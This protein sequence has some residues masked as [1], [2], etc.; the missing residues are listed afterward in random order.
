[1]MRHFQLL[2]R[3]LS[4]SLQAGGGFLGPGLFVVAIAL[5]FAFSSSNDARL[6]REFASAAII[7]PV[8]L[9]CLLGLERLF[10]QSL[11][12]GTLEQDLLLG[13]S[14]GELVTS[15]I[16]AHAVAISLPMLVAVPLVGLMFAQGPAY[17]I[18]ATP[19]ALLTVCAV[20]FAGAGPAALA[21]ER[22]RAALLIAL[23]VPPFLAPCVIFAGGALRA[24]QLG[25]PW[26]GPA[27]L[28]TATTLGALVV[29]V[30]GATAALRMHLD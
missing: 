18:V 22:P 6:L 29:G 12:T 3:D 21:A 13:F 4:R 1:M 24:L 2:G 19:L 28:L 23:M 15:R 16:L 9:T 10:A 26:A 25:D 27:F 30:V 20:T 7:I 17:L 8:A 11:Q 5:L 14:L